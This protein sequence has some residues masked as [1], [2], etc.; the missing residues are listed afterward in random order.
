[1]TL[2]EEARMKNT[3]WLVARVVAASAVALGA[4][5]Q[6]AQAE[7][8]VSASAGVANMYYFRGVDLGNG[9]A[10]VFGDLG[11]SAGGAYGGIWGTSG[12]AAAGTEYDLYAGY[13]HSFGDLSVDV[14]A[15]TYVYP[16]DPGDSDVGD[17]SE[18]ILAVGYGP[19]SVA[20]VDNVAGASGYWYTAVGA[21]FD[22]FSVTYG[23]H[24][25]DYAHLDLGY[26]Y[27]ENLSFIFGIP[28][29]DVDGAYD[30]DPKFV[31]S[32]SLPI[33]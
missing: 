31:V 11:V 30:D 10:A 33:E 21:T 32:Y 25:D 13:G 7:V 2:V 8:E 16:S 9:D 5:A 29:D 14:S 6:T 26:A 20:Y 12:D 17:L 23:L 27:S 18:V 1:M 28:V 22:A 19:F 3:P 15:W 24:E 4:V